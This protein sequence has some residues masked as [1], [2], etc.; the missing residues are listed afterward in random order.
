[1]KDIAFQVAINQ[2]YRDKVKP[3]DGRFWKF[4]MTFHKTRLTLPKLLVAIRQGYAWTAPHRRIR[5]RRP[6]RKNPHYRT[7][8]RVKANVI[9]SQLLA[10]DSD[11][12]D[13]RSQF[14]ALLADPF[15]GRYASLLHATAS[16]TLQSTRT[17]IIFLLEEPLSAAAYEQAL[18]GLLHRYPFC[19]QS[20]N[21]AAAVFYG[22]KN[23]TYRL[24]G[25][26]LPLPALE[27]HILQPYNA[28]MER[29]RQRREAERRAR[30]AA[31]GSQERPAAGQVERYVQA[32][33][34]N[35]LTKLAQTEPG[36]GLRH[37][38]LYGA[39]VTVGGLESAAW[40]TA[41]A[42][43]RLYQAVDDLMAAATANGYTADYG[44]DDAL[45]TIE[46]GLARGALLPLAE[47]VW[48][49]ER[50]FFL[51]GDRVKAVVKGE[52]KAV[53]RVSGLRE[54]RHWEYEIDTKPNVW[55]AR[56]LLRRD[57]AA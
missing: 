16:S 21:H 43:E 49:G 46:N 55:F 56:S 13:E 11:T 42:R 50:P 36:R 20:V 41:A 38:R 24:T 33:C 48:Y 4:N 17:R 34:D 53:G 52:V 2:K 14:D 1:M 22:A 45:R 15:I 12:G 10:L 8:Y 19:D 5:H 18:R 3:G 30:L 25:N 47:P 57:E 28:F 37:Q 7:T 27:S 39:A 6:T 29:E 35:L 26:T 32:T 23:C 54:T 40:L 31:Y 9:G 51:V 44:E